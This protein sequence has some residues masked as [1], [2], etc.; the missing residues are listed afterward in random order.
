MSM[1]YWFV[2]VLRSLLAPSTPTTDPHKSTKQQLS[3]DVNHE[4]SGYC[5]CNPVVAYID[6][7][8]RTIVWKHRT[9]EEAN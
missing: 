3:N 8:S 1:N 6:E 4:N 9:K 5:W 7:Q 2:T